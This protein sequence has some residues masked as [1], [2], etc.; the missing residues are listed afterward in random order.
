MSWID[1]A[2]ELMELEAAKGREI[3]EAVDWKPEPGDTLVGTLMKQAVVYTR[4]GPAIKVW[5]KDRD[6]DV[7]V[8][9]G[10]ASMFKDEYI[11]EAPQVGMGISIRFDGKGEGQYAKALWYVMSE[12]HDQEEARQ[13]LFE[14]FEQAQKLEEAKQAKAPEREP[15]PFNG[16]GE[17]DDLEAPF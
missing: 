11:A 9:F 5:V 4:F 12:P 6:G 8:V 7:W 10:S 13:V 16:S 2:A 1:D 15:S 14:L 17:V 3:E